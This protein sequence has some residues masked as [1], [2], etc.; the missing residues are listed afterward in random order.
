VT[1]RLGAREQ[2]APRARR[3]IGGGAI[4]LIAG[5]T[6]VGTGPSQIG[7]GMTL[8]AL[9]ALIYGIH[10]FGRLGPDEGAAST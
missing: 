6:M 7:T 5:L 1:K 9:V 8:I 4:L 2:S 3:A 10:T